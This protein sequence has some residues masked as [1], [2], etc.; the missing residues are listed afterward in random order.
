MN[1]CLYV[2]NMLCHTLCQA[3]FLQLLEK[4]QIKEGCRQTTSI[5]LPDSL[6]SNVYALYVVG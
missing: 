2:Y 5:R 3:S 1:N 4:D 6:L